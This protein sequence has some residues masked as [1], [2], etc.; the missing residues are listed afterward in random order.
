MVDPSIVK[1]AVDTLA[2]VPLHAECVL[3]CRGDT[4]YFF[5]VYDSTGGRYSWIF[6]S[7][8]SNPFLADVLTL[9]RGSL[10]PVQKGLAERRRRL[11]CVGV[12]FWGESNDPH[13]G[14]EL[15]RYFAGGGLPQEVDLQNRRAADLVFLV[16][17]LD[18]NSSPPR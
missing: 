6:F 15:E 16:D 5:L 10:A 4:G 7:T 12:R 3:T 1:W 17:A 18:P 13:W 8:S 9:A 14:D 2:G 11:R